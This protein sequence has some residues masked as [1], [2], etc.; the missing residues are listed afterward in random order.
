MLIS[1]R[2]NAFSI[3]F[4]NKHVVRVQIRLF[5]QVGVG[6]RLG[7]ATVCFATLQLAGCLVNR[8]LRRLAD[9]DGVTWLNA[10]SCQRLAI[11][12]VPLV[13]ADAAPE[14]LLRFDLGHSRGERHIYL[15]GLLARLADENLEGVLGSHAVPSL[16]K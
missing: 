6:G 7:C 8:G 10:K 3:E 11:L 13:A 16:V 9:A 1:I 14:T 12:A 5:L 15:Q 4:E 2:T